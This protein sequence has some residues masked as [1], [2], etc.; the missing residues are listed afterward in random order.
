MSTGKG[1]GPESAEA[2]R[3][4]VKSYVASAINRGG[5]CGVSCG[6]DIHEHQSYKSR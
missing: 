1:L 2:F 3:D 4:W 6:V 5:D